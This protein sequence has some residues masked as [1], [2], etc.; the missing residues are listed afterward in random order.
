VEVEEKDTYGKLM[1]DAGVSGKISIAIY[2]AAKEKYDLAKIRLGKF[3]E[4]VT[5]KVAKN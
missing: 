1:E 2:E 4:L 3:L 5:M